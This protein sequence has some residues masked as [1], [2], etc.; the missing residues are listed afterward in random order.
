M[1]RKLLEGME[2][3]GSLVRESG[4]D[5]G[6]AKARVFFGSEPR[7]RQPQDP[8]S[9]NEPGAPSVS[10]YYSRRAALMIQL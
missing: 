2:I 6:S 4:L 3:D 7:K 10:P 1:G 8:G 9:K 5:A